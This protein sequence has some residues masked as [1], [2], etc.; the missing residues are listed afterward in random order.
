M[1]LVKTIMVARWG[2][3]VGA[4]FAAS[5]VS[6]A[7]ITV[8]VTPPSLRVGDQAIVS[9]QLESTQEEVNAVAGTVVIPPFLAVREVRDGGSVMNFWIRRLTTDGSAFSGVIPGG[10]QGERA[11]LFSLV[12][13]GVIEGRG[14]L[15]VNDGQVLRNDG[16]GTVAPLVVRPASVTVAHAVPAVAPA[17]VPVVPDA[18]PPEPFALQLGRAPGVLD[19]RWFVVFAT[20][21]KDSGIARYEVAEWRG[22]RLP[23]AKQLTWRLAESPYPISDQARRSY[24]VVRATDRA[25]NTWVSVLPPVAAMKY[26]FWLIWAILAV[27]I[28]AIALIAWRR[29]RRSAP[30]SVHG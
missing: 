18:T 19:G 27:G 13:E 11:E 9:F 3:V 15:G 26:K 24:V 4:V 20:Q 17:V 30:P 6:A 16:S 22:S 8:E 10:F 25:G 5:V 21:D 2:A 1:N 7:T 12:V 28:V 23:P 29:S 14:D